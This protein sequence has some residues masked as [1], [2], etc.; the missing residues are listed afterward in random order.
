MVNHVNRLMIIVS[1]LTD[2]TQTPA[3][4]VK[5]V[6]PYNMKSKTE[7]LIA[8]WHYW[9]TIPRRVR[10]VHLLLAPYSVFQSFVYM[11]VF[12]HGGGWNKTLYL[13]LCLKTPVF[14]I[15]PLCD[16]PDNG[17]SVPLQPLAVTHT[18][19]AFKGKGGAMEPKQRVWALFVRV[20][21]TRHKNY[22]SRWFC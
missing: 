19:G 10:L 11:L 1:S 4:W 2:E 7:F 15:Q 18:W 17:Q 21:D 22:S 16:H 13:H 6:W 12:C 3:C 8:F 5:L 9:P 20:D 14:K